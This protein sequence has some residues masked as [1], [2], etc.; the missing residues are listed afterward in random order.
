MPGL[1]Y[2]PTEPNVLYARTDVAG[3]YRWD[4]PTAKWISITDMFGFGEGKFQGV[5]SIALDPTDANMVWSQVTG[6]SSCQMIRADISSVGNSPIR[7]MAL[8]VPAAG[9]PYSAAVYFMGRL[10]V[11]SDHVYGVD[12]SPRA[13]WFAC[14]PAPE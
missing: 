7:K 11:G 9:S 2:H 14:A 8:G 12:N 4:Q 3:T 13:C 10:L 6:L 1:I 5:A